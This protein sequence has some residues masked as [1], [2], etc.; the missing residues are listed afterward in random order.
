MKN[1][2]LVLCAIIFDLVIYLLILC[3]PRKAQRR[4]DI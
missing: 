1:P 3:L 4:A 2:L